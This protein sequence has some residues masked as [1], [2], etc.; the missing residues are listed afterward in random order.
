MMRGLEDLPYEERETWGCSTWRMKERAG[1][2]SAYK[3]AYKNPKSRSQESRLFSVVCINRTRGS[4]QKLE[5]S[6]CEANM[7]RYYFAA[8]V[9]EHWNRLP[10]EVVE[11]PSLEVLKTHL[12]T[13]LC[14]LFWGTCLSTG[15]N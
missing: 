7:R 2:I 11:N 4:K 14:K 10:R 15:L 5:H 3:Y 9:T 13:F 1:L 6:M 12:D 8:G